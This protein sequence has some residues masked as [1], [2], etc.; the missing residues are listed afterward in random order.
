MKNISDTT[1][2]VKQGSVE[3]IESGRQIVQ[4]MKTLDEATKRML[5]AM[6]EMAAGTDSITSAIS[7]VDECSTRNKASIDNLGVEIQFFKL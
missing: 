1:A 2:T 7:S 6:T 3:M 4:E 5:D